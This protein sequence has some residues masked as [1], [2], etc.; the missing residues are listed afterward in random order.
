[1][2]PTY[3]FTT[4]HGETVEQVFSIHDDIPASVTLPSGQTAFRDLVMEHCGF[5]DK[6]GH[7]PK[8]SDALGVHPSQV[9]EAMEHDRAHG[10]PTDYTKDGRAILKDRQHFTALRKLH[11]MNDR[12][13]YD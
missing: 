1:M 8:K 11:G 5:N 2:A 4:H 9:K 12:S 10:V 3:C 6:S 7:W 13:G